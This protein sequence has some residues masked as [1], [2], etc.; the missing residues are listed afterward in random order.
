MNKQPEGEPVVFV[1][2][3]MA[4]GKASCEA[5]VTEWISISHYPLSGATAVAR[6]LSAWEEK[7]E[8][9]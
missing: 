6:L 7:L 2:G 1:L 8:I 5:D 4:H 3:A 9:L